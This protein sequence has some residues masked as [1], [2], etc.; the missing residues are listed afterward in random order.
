M[1]NPALRRSLPVRRRKAPGPRKVSKTE[2]WLNLL[3]YLCDRR[4]PVTREQIF[5][6]VGGYDGAEETG[7]RKFERD[8][9]E[10]RALG[11]EIETVPVAGMIGRAWD[12]VRLWFE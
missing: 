8:K 9:D 6:K 2:R 11:V 7:R 4:T 5:H 10:L 1:A 12:S 3:A